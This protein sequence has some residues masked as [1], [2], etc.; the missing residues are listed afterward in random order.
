MGV[1]I[2]ACA[3]VEKMGGEINEG[4]KKQIEQNLKSNGFESE[5][6]NYRT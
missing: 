1:C 5:N 2:G 4:D 6:C 3:R